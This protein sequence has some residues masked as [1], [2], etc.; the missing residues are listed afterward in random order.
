MSMGV[1]RWL[2]VGI[3]GYVQLSENMGGYVWLWMAIGGYV[4]LCVAMCLF[5]WL[6]GWLCATM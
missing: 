2:W 5:G 1:Y 4:H 3:C 6:V